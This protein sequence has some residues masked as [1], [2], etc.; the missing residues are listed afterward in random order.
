MNEQCDV[1]I[2]AAGS[3]TRLGMRQPKAFVTLAGKPICSYSIEVFAAHPFVDCITLVVPANMKDEVTRLFDGEKIRVVAGGDQRWM[4]VRNGCVVSASPWVMVHDAARPFVSC[5]VIDALLE[6]RKSFDCAIT[7][8]PVVDTIRTFSG[9]VAGETVDRSKL[10]RVGT[11]QLFRRELLMK[12]FSFVDSDTELPTDE[13][14]LMQRMDVAVGI[15]DGD[16]M[17]FKITTKEDLEIARAIISGR[18]ET[19]GLASSR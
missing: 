2:V 18:K 1:I 8:T 5:R 4:S 16:P 9:E 13:A 19:A 6:K 11:P 15:A 10:V 17:N 12:A 14:V 3:G 7:A